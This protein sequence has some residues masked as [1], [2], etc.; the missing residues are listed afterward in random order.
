MGKLERALEI[1]GELE[2]VRQAVLIDGHNLAELLVELKAASTAGAANVNARHHMVLAN[3][4]DLLDAPASK[5]PMPPPRRSTI[6]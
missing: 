4:A 2:E 6:S 3:R 5:T 1:E